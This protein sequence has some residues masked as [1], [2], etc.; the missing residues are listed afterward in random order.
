MGKIKSPKV[1][2]RNVAGEEREAAAAA[3]RLRERARR[4][5]G[6]RANVLAGPLAALSRTT[7]PTATAVPAAAAELG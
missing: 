6:R 7:Q 2:R 5:Q 1:P 3:A 4:S